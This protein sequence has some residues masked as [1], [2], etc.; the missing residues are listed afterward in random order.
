MA[1]ALAAVA[2]V[3]T[4]AD[5]L[6]GSP[7]TTSSAVTTTTSPLLSH[8]RP[9]SPLNPTRR[10]PRRGG[11]KYEDAEIPSRATATLNPIGPSLRIEHSAVRPARDLP[12]G[13]EPAALDAYRAL[14]L[15]DGYVPVMT[16]PEGDL[17]RVVVRVTRAS[18][19][20]PLR[21]I[22]ATADG[23]VLVPFDR[24]RK[25]NATSTTISPGWRKPYDLSLWFPLGTRRGRVYLT[26]TDGYPSSFLD[27]GSD[28][29]ALRA[30]WAIDV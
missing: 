3:L 27:F 16:R 14:D 4:S 11:A 19:E 21:C 6:P 8:L 20:N 26:C 23:T 12:S 22:V 30:V 7:T 1:A 24:A 9:V 10:Y 2:I 5:G 25:Y 28:A 15:V 18:N 13:F 17:L 29:P